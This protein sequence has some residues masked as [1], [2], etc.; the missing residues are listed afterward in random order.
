MWG[1]MKCK[2]CKNDIPDE[3]HFTFCGYCGER[4]IPERKKKDAIKIPKARLRGKKWYIE[5]RREGV[6]IIEDTEAEAIAK[7]TAIR[8]GIIE[9]IKKHPPLTLRAAIDEYIAERSNILSPS[10]INGYRTIQRHAFPL[11]MG[12]DIYSVE[13][14]QTVI[15]SEAERVSAKTL[16]NEWGLVNSVLLRHD[17]NVGTVLLPQIIHRELPWLDY[18]QIEQFLSAIKG[19]SCELAALFALHGLRRSE[20]LALTPAKIYDGIIHI[21]GSAV[22]NEK[23]KLVMK[24]ENKNS[25]SRRNVPIMI[26]R[27]SE[28]I[29]AHTGD[30]N[31][32]FIQY[33]DIWSRINNICEKNG[34][35]KVGVHGLRRSFASLAYHLKWSE[36]QTMA[37]GG[38]SDLKTVHNIYVKLADGDKSADVD[39]MKQFYSADFTAKFTT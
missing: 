23:N 21:E 29:A 12:E 36:R 17:I 28:M 9:V 32:P 39:A 6:T 26:P 8:A 27:L 4:L 38:W 13:N 31:T 19:T 2:H 24:E 25:S 3:L 15:N 35:P 20:I 37:M 14:W 33:R 22:L 30:A 5:L 11:I 18:S 34:L 16:K 7:A 10:T 1:E